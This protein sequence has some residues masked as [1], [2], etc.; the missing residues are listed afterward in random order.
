MP[1]SISSKSDSVQ[2][3]YDN[4]LQH[5]FI[6]NRRYQRK[7]VWSQEEKIAFIDSIYK[8]YSVPLFL[9]AQTKGPQ[10]NENTIRYEIIDGMQRLNAVTSFIENEFPIEYNGEKV[11]FD[12]ETLASSKD[13]LDKNELVQKTPK[14]PRD[15]CI[16]ITSYQMPFTYIIADEKDIEEIFR[17]INSFGRQLS[18]QEIRQAGALGPFPDL[19]RKLSS[20]IR[21]DTSPDKLLLNQMKEISL[22]NKNLNYGI[23]LNKVFWVKQQIIT[24]QNMRISR[25]E[26]LIAWIVSY[27]VFGKSIE[28][29]AKV[30]NRLYQNDDDEE[31]IATRMKIQISQIGEETIT[32]WF[33]RVFLVLIRILEYSHEKYQ[34]NF[35]ALMF[36][37]KNEVEGLVRTF[38]VVFLSLFELVIKDKMEICNLDEL[39]SALKGLGQN[40]LS[41]I[42]TEK[43]TSSKRFNMIQSVK[44]IM[45]PYF[46]LKTGE[47]V[48]NEDWTIELRNIFRLSKIEGGQYDFKSGFHR[49]DNKRSSIDLEL[50]SKC[51]KLLTAAVNKGPQTDG[52]VIFGVTEGESSFKRYQEFYKSKEGEKF[53][54]THFYITGIDD[55]AR[56]FYSGKLDMVQNDIINIIKNEPIDNDTRQFILTH[57]KFPNYCGRTLLV[58]HLQSKDKPIAYND[59]YYI[60]EGNN[61]IELSG[62]QAITALI[63]RFNSNQ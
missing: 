58:L 55:E 45:Q 21:N 12:L 50:V 38:Q 8:Q 9:L 13:L 31:N 41:A 49:F 30:L 40:H 10:D 36:T 5:K 2:S 3:V 47:N 54:N 59:R 39:V 62:A 48:A 61:S 63:N 20:I 4:Y 26:E 44:G 19:V 57:M 22:T 6:V 28:P 18:N 46:K 53:E 16:K 43:W 15:E 23:D 33:K 34:K 56:K 29:T 42:K 32:S 7:L 14:L 27:M 52:Y 37:D 51:V 1:T 24:I 25:D 17:R 60:R 35:C 11:Y